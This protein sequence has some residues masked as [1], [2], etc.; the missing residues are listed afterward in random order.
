MPSV[1]DVCKR[2]DITAW[3][4]DTYFPDVRRRI[5]EQHRRC[6]SDGTTRRREKLFHDVRDIA[7]R[8]QS[9]GLHPST[10]RIVEPLPDG[11]S[12]EWKALTGA[13][14]EAHMALGISK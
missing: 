2:L 10:N 6:V 7:A 5:A 1:G 3:F 9:E 11:S 14:R 4:M 8:L 13:V 12:R